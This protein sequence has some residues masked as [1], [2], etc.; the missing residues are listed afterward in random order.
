MA[1]ESFG[2]LLREAREQKNIDIECIFKI[3]FLLFSKLKIP[4]KQ[5]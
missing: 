2:K 5:T 3:T 4:S 1:M